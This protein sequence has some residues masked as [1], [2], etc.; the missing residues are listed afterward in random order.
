M[1]RKGARADQSA[2]SAIRH[3]RAVFGSSNSSALRKA[4]HQC[5]PVVRGVPRNGDPP[6]AKQPTP[7]PSRRSS[8][9]ADQIRDFLADADKRATAEYRQRPAEMYPPS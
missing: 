6:P 3:E 1:E 9:R 5:P 8:F 2:F 7:P 4:R